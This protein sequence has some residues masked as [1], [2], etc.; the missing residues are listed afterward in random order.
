MNYKFYF[1]DFDYT[2]VNSEKGIVGCFLKTM[3]E[4]HIPPNPWDEIKMTIGMPMQDA[5]THLTGL[6]DPAEL[7]QFITIYKKYANQLMTD[8]T[9]FFPDTVATLKRLKEAG[10]TVGIVST[11]TRRRINEKFQQE[12]CSHLIDLVIGSEDTSACKPDPQGINMALDRTG[13]PRHQAVYVGDSIYDAGAAQNAGLD[14]VGVLTG[15]TSA[16]A[17][18]AYPSVQIINHLGEL[19]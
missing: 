19:L 11:K 15:N 16:E 18:K 12:G 7:Q 4:L 10:C 3:E 14:F 2:L 9:H 8:N 5:V 1:F 17:L 6:T 13:A